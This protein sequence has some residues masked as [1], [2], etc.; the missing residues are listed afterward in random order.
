MAK[1]DPDAPVTNQM[2]NEAVEAILSRMNQ[3]LGDVARKDDLKDF[4]TKAD[5][6]NIVHD[7]LTQYHADMVAPEIERLGKDI[8]SLQGGITEL[9]DNMQNVKNDVRWMKDDVEG[10]KAEIS[11]TPNRHEFESLRARVQKLEKASIQ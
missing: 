2:L 8:R 5:V 11:T 7:Q 9:N 6:E 10:I 3:M 1:P 4:A